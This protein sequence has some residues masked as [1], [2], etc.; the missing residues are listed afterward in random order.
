MSFFICG[1]H[2]AGPIMAGAIYDR[3]LRYTIALLDIVGIAYVRSA[4]D[5][6][7]DPAVDKLHDRNESKPA[8]NFW[9]N[10]TSSRG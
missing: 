6:A 4:I 7:F 5:C 10:T 9:L 2:F 3:T 1:G 8:M